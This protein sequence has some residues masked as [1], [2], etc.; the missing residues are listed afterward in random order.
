MSILTWEMLDRNHERAAVIGG[1]LVK[2]YEDILEAPNGG[3][4][5]RGSNVRVTMC[6]VPDEGHYWK[7]NWSVK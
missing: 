5:S 4:A 6:F 2:A 1:W 7:S 3:A